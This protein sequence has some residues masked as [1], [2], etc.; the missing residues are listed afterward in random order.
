MKSKSTQERD[1]TKQDII[2]EQ[3]KEKERNIEKLKEFI[4]NSKGNI[5]N[6]QMQEYLNISDASVT[7]YLDELE[8]MRLIKQVGKEGTAVF[9][10]KI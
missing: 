9:Y 8:S 6:D 10:E 5:T 4:A 1:V 3:A 7:R 2:A